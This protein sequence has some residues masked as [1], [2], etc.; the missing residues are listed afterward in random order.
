MG[1]EITAPFVP[2]VVLRCFGAWE[3]VSITVDKYKENFSQL[4]F[5]YPQSLIAPE[6][7]NMKQARRVVGRLSQINPIA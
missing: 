6:V 2:G 7:V 3:S 1:F 5:D 4:T